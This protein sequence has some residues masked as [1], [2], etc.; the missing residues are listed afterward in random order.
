MGWGGVRDGLESPKDVGAFHLRRNSFGDSTPT[1]NLPLEG[2]LP[3]G[4]GDYLRPNG[5]QPRF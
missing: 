5:N 2:G 1:Q 3:A 4:P